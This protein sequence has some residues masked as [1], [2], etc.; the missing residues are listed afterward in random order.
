MT[1]FAWKYSSKIIFKL[2]KAVRNNTI[3]FNIHPDPVIKL[4]NL[5]KVGIQDIF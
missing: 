4:L 3:K 2:Q 5:L 1:F